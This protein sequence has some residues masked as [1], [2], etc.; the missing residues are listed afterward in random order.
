MTPKEKIKVI[1]H[2]V[3]E[4]DVSEVCGQLNLMDYKD[5]EM[6]EALIKEGAKKIASNYLKCEMSGFTDNLAD[7]ASTT[8]EIVDLEH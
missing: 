2:R 4:V 6:T 3:Y 1:F 8:V 5:E 7:F